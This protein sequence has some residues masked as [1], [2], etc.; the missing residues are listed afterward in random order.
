MG[1]TGRA[2]AALI[3]LGVAG[4]VRQAHES[5]AV[6]AGRLEPARVDSRP[7]ARHLGPVAGAV[8]RWTPPRPRTA[9]G[10][11]AAALWAGPVTVI[12]ALLARLGG[13]RPVRDDTHGLWLAAG[14]RGLPAGVLRIVGMGAVTMG[15]VVLSRRSRLSSAMLAHEA[16]HVRQFERLGPLLPPLY[17]WWAVRH[18]YRH[19]PLEQAA[20]RAAAARPREA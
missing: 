10:R 7:E 20:R 8:A 18:G 4:A 13:R 1:W 5:R 19:H 17:A 2:V 3:A 9:A 16:A 6:R 14:A 12:G 15:Q 11:L